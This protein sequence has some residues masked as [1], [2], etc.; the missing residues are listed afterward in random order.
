MAVS[1]VSRPGQ[2][3]QTVVGKIVP[4]RVLDERRT[5]G[6]R[7]GLWAD[8]HALTF[9]LFRG[10]LEPIIARNAESFFIGCLTVALVGPH[11][12]PAISWIIDAV[13]TQV[14]ELAQ[15]DISVESAKPIVAKALKTKTITA[16]QAQELVSRIMVRG[17]TK[18]LTFEEAQYLIDS[19]RVDDVPIKSRFKELLGAAEQKLL[20]RFGPESPLAQK[21]AADRAFYVLNG[22]IPLPDI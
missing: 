4:K 11:K 7:Q 15:E 8:P 10:E 21:V 22:S 19:F 14:P 2:A 17:E 5:F 20:E 9:A 1:S 18:S 16:K 13:K 3:V 12:D 6:F